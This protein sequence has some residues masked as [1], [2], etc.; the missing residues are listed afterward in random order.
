MKFYENRNDL[1][2]LLKDLLSKFNWVQANV[3][4]INPNYTD[5]P[6]DISGM[7]NNNISSDDDD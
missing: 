2:L 5:T 1:E 6:S 3:P 7:L 4:V